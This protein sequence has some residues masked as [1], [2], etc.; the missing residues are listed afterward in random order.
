[1]QTRGTAQPC[2]LRLLGPSGP[3][4]I[5]PRSLSHVRSVLRG[6]PRPDDIGG[7]QLAAVLRINRD[8]EVRLK[9]CETAL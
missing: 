8:L 5:P 3:P 6:S 1:M 2:S 4:R 9:E 7:S